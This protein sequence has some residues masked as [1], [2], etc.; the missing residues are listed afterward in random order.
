MPII[1]TDDAWEQYQAWQHGD[2][3]T[4]KRINK[5]IQDIQRNGAV[6]IGKAEPLRGAEGCWSRRIDEKNRL[7]YKVE[8]E[9]I[10]ITLCGSHYGK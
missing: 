6:G 8:G 2:A 5:L 10:T 3:K 7:V 1:F 4:L 9:N